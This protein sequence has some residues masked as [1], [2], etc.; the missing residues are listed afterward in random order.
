MLAG[1]VTGDTVLIE[2]QPT[3]TTSGW[4]LL[5]RHSS[6]SRGQKWLEDKTVPVYELAVV[7]RKIA[8][9]AEDPPVKHVK[10]PGLFLLMQ[11]DQN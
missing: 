8:T 11:V 9:V 5:D 3:V 6:Y 7:H 4:Q 10:D 1:G 2:I